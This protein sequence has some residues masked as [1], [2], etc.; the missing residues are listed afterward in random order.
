MQQQGEEYLTPEQAAGLI[1]VS[2]R[3]IER[4]ASAGKIKKYGRGSR[5]YYK[6]SEVEDAGRIK[7]TEVKAK[8][9]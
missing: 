8:E 3:T 5:T 7:E 6:K 9:S 2:R 1:G 4:Y